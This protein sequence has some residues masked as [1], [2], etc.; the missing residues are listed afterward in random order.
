MCKLIFT[1][2]MEPSYFGS[3]V[4]TPR[5]YKA[6][7]RLKRKKERET[8]L[9]NRMELLSLRGVVTPFLLMH[10]RVGLDCIGG[11]ARD[12]AKPCE[13]GV[14]DSSRVGYL[15]CVR[16]SYIPC[17]NGG[18]Y[19]MACAAFYEQGFNVPSH[20]YLHSL[21]QFYS[22]E[23]HHMSPLWILHMASFVTL[24]EAYMGIEPHFNLWNYFRA[25]LQLA[26]DVETV[27]LG[28]MD[29]FV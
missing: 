15:S 13:S 17:S 21:L 20:R 2:P 11:H 27:A 19:I 10:A 6:G 24:C 5:G 28:K 1:M 8:D 14:Y 22:L 16:G 7:Q 23:L 4:T 12:P 29:I 18:G 25:Q 3:S 26:S 9:E